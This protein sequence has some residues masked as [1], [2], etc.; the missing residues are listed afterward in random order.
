[1]VKYNEQA[2]NPVA[3]YGVG[4]LPIVLLCTTVLNAIKFGAILIVAMVLCNLLY[5]AFKPIVN[6]NV[7]IPCYVLLIIGV[8][9]LIDSVLSEFSAENTSNVT[10]LV[11]YLFSATVIIYMFETSSKVKNVQSSLL[12]CLIMGGEYAIC[13]ICVGFFRELLG[14]G[15]LFGAKIF[16]GGIAFFASNIGAILLVLIYAFIY[17]MVVSNVKKKS[18]AYSGLVDRYELFLENKY[19]ELTPM[20]S[21]TVTTS[22]DVTAGE[23]VEERSISEQKEGGK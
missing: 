7:R 9:Y 1:M 10:N 5:F 18:I 11:S 8:E 4:L 3:F 16:N 13:M 15:K 23:P 2:L 22:T 19:M 17:N 21:N 12:D 6:E 20:K 14:Q